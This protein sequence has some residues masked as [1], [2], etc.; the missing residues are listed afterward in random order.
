MIRLY[1]FAFIIFWKLL[2][3][4]C[5][6]LLPVAQ[7]FHPWQYSESYHE[8]QFLSWMFCDWF[9]FR[10]IG[11]NIIF[12]L[13]FPRLAEV[14][15]VRSC[16]GSGGNCVILIWLRYE[17]NIQLGV[18]YFQ[19]C[20][21][22]PEQ[23]EQSL[24]SFLFCQDVDQQLPANCLGKDPGSRKDEQLVEED[25]DADDG[26]LVP[27][28][29]CPGHVR[30]ISARKGPADLNFCFKIFSCTRILYSFCM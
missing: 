6:H 11:N 5:C 24:L 23:D 2:A 27:V 17:Y 13:S 21:L 8:D 26:D 22:F 18:I 14:L 3:R 1:Y 7:P 9:L 12:F 30:F 16:K 25:G 4:N 20:C 28:E 10:I 15:A 29:I 19:L